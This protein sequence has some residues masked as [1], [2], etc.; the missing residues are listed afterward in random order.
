MITD[1]ENAKF[2]GMHLHKLACITDRL[3]AHVLKNQFNLTFPQ[4]FILMA[5]KK[6]GNISQT[7]VAQYHGLTEAAISKQI[8]QLQ[9][10]QYVR[11]KINASNRREHIL[12]LAPQG[13]EII[14]KAMKILSQHFATIFN[15]L[16]KEDQKSF[17]QNLEKVSASADRFIKDKLSY[18]K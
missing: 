10:I 12:Q 13:S 15:I 17:G 16:S 1:F 9:K 8:T 7:T 2:I 3:A 14:K 6:R 4:F 5:L 11:K 18:A